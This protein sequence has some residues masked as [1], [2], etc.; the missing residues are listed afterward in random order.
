MPQ[1]A[2]MVRILSILGMFLAVVGS[3]YGNDELA[4][5]APLSGEQE[6]SVC[7]A[8]AWRGHGHRWAVTLD[9]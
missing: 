3:A 4:F 1:R 7:R 9:F 5:I 2:T 8:P 6:I